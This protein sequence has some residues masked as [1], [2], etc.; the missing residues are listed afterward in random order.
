MIG[1]KCGDDLTDAPIKLREFIAAQS[2]RAN[3]NYQESKVSGMQPGV[4]YTNTR[5]TV[6][7]ASVSGGLLYVNGFRVGSP[8][9]ILPGQTVRADLSEE[10][11]NF[12]AVMEHQKVT[13]S[14]PLLEDWKEQR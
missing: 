11:S 6:A 1:M 12:F 13:V 8:C 9:L 5:D 2:G 4:T 7:L 3:S 10:Y 14:K